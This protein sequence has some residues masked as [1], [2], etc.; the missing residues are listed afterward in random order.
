MNRK[1]RSLWIKALESGRY[2][3]ARTRLVV[4]KNKHYS[5]CCLGVLCRVAGARFSQDGVPSLGDMHNADLEGRLADAFLD[6]VK[7]SDLDQS[8][9]IRLNDTE[10]ATFKD[11]AKWIRKNVK[12]TPKGK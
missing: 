5:Y 10:K 9:L 2:K 4:K 7:L 12:I 6:H 8:E 1:I 3:Q 11:I